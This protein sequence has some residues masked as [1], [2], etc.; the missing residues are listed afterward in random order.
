M[1]SANKHCNRNTA[2]ETQARNDV[3]GEALVEAQVRGRIG[4][5]ELECC[6]DGGGAYNT[7]RGLEWSRVR[8]GVGSEVSQE[9]SME[10]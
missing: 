6:I 5:G 1:S 3:C 2:A 10:S 9:G 4:P 8:A 7:T